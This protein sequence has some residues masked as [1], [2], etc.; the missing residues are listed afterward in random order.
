MECIKSAITDAIARL[1]NSSD[2]PRLDAEVLLS[3]TLQKNRTYLRT[4]PEQ[5]LTSEQIQQFKKILIRRCQGTPI[6]YIT[7][8]REF[9]S[10]DFVVNDSVLIPRPDTELLIE[11][12]LELI[13]QQQHY[14]L[15]DLGTGSG[16]IGITLAAERPLAGVYATDISK[17]ALT[18]AKRN[19]DHYG[20]NNIRF[21][22]S[23]WL[24]AFNRAEFDLVISNPPYIDKNDPH[25][26]LGDVRFEPKSALIA[27]NRG[28]KD[29]KIIVETAC[30][31]LNNNGH[32]LVEHGYEQ[33]KS[34]QQIFTDCHYKNIQTHLDL[35]GHPRVTYGQWRS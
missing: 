24:G 2:S 5:R 29:I 11:R 25:L 13:P 32:L 18:L 16:I 27:E 28:L 10:R 9:W 14:Q 19:A 7:G 34:V 33:H 17:D 1:Q 35:S 30:M 15:I 31:H 26:S 21:I 3:L 20:L 22:E 12:A 23:D 6:A 8:H 4:W